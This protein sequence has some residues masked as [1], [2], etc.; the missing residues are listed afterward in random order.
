MLTLDRVHYRDDARSEI[1]SRNCREF[2]SHFLSASQKEDSREKGK[3]KKRMRC[4]L[5]RRHL[6]NL[7]W[8]QSESANCLNTSEDV[9]EVLLILSPSQPG[10]SRQRWGACGKI[11]GICRI[12]FIIPVLFAHCYLFSLCSIISRTI[13]IMITVGKNTE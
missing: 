1:S 6:R 11:S 12:C 4:R 8:F 5:Q 10:R 7:S 3:I 9:A 2:G 13:M